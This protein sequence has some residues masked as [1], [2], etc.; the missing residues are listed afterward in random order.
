[1]P[2]D[3]RHK[4]ETRRG[5]LAVLEQIKLSHVKFSCKRGLMVK[6]LKQWPQKLTVVFFFLI[7]YFFSKSTLLCFL[8]RFR[9]LSIFDHSG[10]KS[11]CCCSDG[12]PHDF[13][14]LYN[15]SADRLK[16]LTPHYQSIKCKEKRLRISRSRFPALC[17]G[18]LYLFRVII[19][20]FESLQML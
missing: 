7:S 11:V 12:H 2:L 20:S 19:G 9:V 13:E 18:H 6:K 5:C 1:M 15:Y 10:E 17:A 3:S 14:L 16:N 8:L 4:A